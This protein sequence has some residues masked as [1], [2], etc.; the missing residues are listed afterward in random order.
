MRTLRAYMVRLAGLFQ[1]DRQDRELAREL[2]SHLQMHIADGVRSGMTPEQARKLAILKLGGV[3]RTKEVYRERRGLPLLETLWQ[4]VRYGLRGLRKNPGLT[5]ILI[6]TLSLGV[7]ANAA[8]FSVVNSLLLRPL[9]V[10]HGSEIDVLTMQQK[11]GALSSYFSYADFHDIREQAHAAFAD[12][13]AFRTSFDGLGVNGQA[14]R[15]MTCYVTGNY[16]EMLGLQPALGR[17][18]APSEG[19]VPGA[20]PIMVLDYSYWQTHLGGNPGIVG[21]KV[22]INGHPITVIGVAPKAFHG[23]V[24]LVQTQGYLPISLMSYQ[25]FYS[26]DYLTNRNAR[27]LHVFAR[28]KEGASLA[29]GNSVLAV[30]A[31]RLSQDHPADD[32]AM[33]LSAF[34]E[35]LSRPAP[36]PNNPLVGISAL[37][38]ALAALVLLLACMNVANILMV[39]ATVRRREMAIR[40]AIGGTRGRLIRQLLTETML[41]AVLGGVGGVLLALW[42]TATLAATDLHIGIPLA[43]DFHFDWRVFAYALGAAIFT[44]LAVGIV[45]AL[46]GSR[47]GLEAVLRESGRGTSTRRQRLRILMVI[48]EVAGSMVLLII[49]ALFVRSLEHSQRISLGFDPQHVLNL[50]MDPYELGYNEAQGREFYKELLGRVRDLPG[51]QSATLAFTVPMRAY[52][53][54]TDALQMEGYQPPAGQAP[55]SVSF[56]IVTPGY[57]ETLRIP[58]SAGRSFRD[59]DDPKSPHVA[60]INQAMANKFWPGQDPIGRKFQLINSPTTSIQVA[61]VARDSK[62]L[63]VF[64]HSEPYFYLPFAQNYS[65]YETLQIRAAGSSSAVLRETQNA[66]AVLAPGLPIFDVETMPESLSSGPFLVFRLGAVLSAVLGI[67]GLALALVGVYGV[68]S[69]ST[70]QRT[71]EIGIR[72][73]LGAQPRQILVMTLR[74]GLGIAAVGML[75]GL[76]LMF[77]AARVVGRFLTV[78]STDTIAYL[79]VSAL[80]AL[81]TAIA[82]YVPARRA[83]RVNPVSALRHE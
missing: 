21:Q 59:S 14:D 64:E 65:S 72:L 57:F 63:S 2:E 45:P 18:I 46:R 38:L 28:Q 52:A 74:Q 25:A 50:S 62:T 70:A 82:C 36:T 26:E 27:S 44:G 22:S 35:T 30:V 53:I 10:S 77:G 60:V 19:V 37:F 68:I 8:I 71:H 16:F 61:G 67:V 4:D 33:A 55:P 5:I 80:L 78:A 12:M 31:Q 83:T 3:E 20:D 48:A 24:S 43:L 58:M 66:I 75:V 49:A 69:Y 51:V 54:N 1:K 40:A 47:G 81:V 17:L 76:M 9:R 32:K 15:I 34:P 11:E 39:R 56:N 13:L 29:F 23:L 6:L 42:A 79:S 7:G 73:A 41:L